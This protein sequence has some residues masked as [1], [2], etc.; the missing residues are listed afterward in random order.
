M[1]ELQIE[2]SLIQKL[3]DLKY[4]YRPEIMNRAGLEQNFREKS[5][6]LRRPSAISTA[7]PATTA[8]R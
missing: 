4:V 7:L 3:S 5:S 1:N 2:Q 6:P 8:R